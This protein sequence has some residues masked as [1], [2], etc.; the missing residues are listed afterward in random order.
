MNYTEF[1]LKRKRIN[2]CSYIKGDK[3][4]S[5]EKDENFVGKHNDIPLLSVSFSFKPQATHVDS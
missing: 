1:N 5:V 2:F 3:I 4:E